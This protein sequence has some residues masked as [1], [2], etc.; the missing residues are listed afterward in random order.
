[1]HVLYR[2]IRVSW[3]QF[4]LYRFILGIVLGIA[5]ALSGLAIADGESNLPA[6]ASTQSLAAIATPPAT[7]L[8][9]QGRQA[10][11]AQRFSEAVAAWE[12]AAALL[13]N[14]PLQQ[15]LAFSYLTAAY[16]Q[17]SQWEVG[18]RTITQSLDILSTAP[19]SAQKLA[20]SAQVHNTLGSLQFARGQTQ[21]ALE[22]WQTAADLYMQAGDE[23]RIFNSLL[24]QI[25]AQQALGYYQ[26]VQ[27]TL[28]TLE[29]R[30]PE[31][32][33]PL[34]VRGY[35]RLGQTYRVLG[36]LTTAQDHLQTALSLA[37][38]RNIATAVILLELANTVQGQGDWEGAIALYHQAERDSDTEI[39]LKARLNRLKLLVQHN[40][41]AARQVASTLPTEIAALPPGRGQIYAYI[42]ASQSLLQLKTPAEVETAAR[43]LAQAVQ[44]SLELQDTR[45]EAYARG[46]LGHAYE[47]SQQWAEAQTLTEQALL[48]AE[49]LNAADIA[50]QWHW[51]Q[52]RLFKQQ[53]QREPALQAYRAAFSTL[54]SLK[55]D[56]VAVSDDLQFSFRDSVEP[57]YR[58][59]VD[60]LL[61][62]DAAMP[63]GL[64]EVASSSAQSRLT[65]ARS[66]IEALQIAELN[67]FFRTACLEAQQVDLEQVS[68]AT[69]AIIY[70]I[71]LPDRLE[72]IASLPGQ[73]LRQYTSPVAQADLEQTLLKWRQFLEKPFT[74]PEGQALGQ[75]LYSW[76]I[77]PMQ[78]ALAETASQTL[79]FVLDGA[80]RNTPMA[81]LYDGDRYLVE[82]YAIA[83]SPGLQ[84]LA[85]RSLQETQVSVLLGG[86]TEPRHG[87]SALFN[88]KDELQT[89][90]AL[91]NSRVLLDQGFTTAALAQQVERT[92]LPIVHLATHGQFS[93]NL[94]DTFIL[95][96]D[97][98]M[99]VNELSR[100]L[101]TGDQNR[102]EP[103]EL[104]V[105]SAC[106]TATGDSRAALG[107]AGISLQSGARST[108]ASLWNLDDASGAYFVSQFYQALAQPHTTKAAALR[109]AQRSLLNN[110]NY[111]HPT[112]WSAYVLVGNW[113]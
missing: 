37:Q 93:S 87:F 78:T 70:P 89:I 17:L 41:D 67:N 105:L 21:S 57:V 16:Q 111:R 72:I 10:Y 27:N 81:A 53:G 104:L 31:Q 44:Q 29:Q 8:L 23:S 112:Y 5:I 108:L 34:Q 77:E 99:P 86:L 110:P 68:Q 61:Q 9:D 73:P 46:Y 63:R 13:S 85:P 38:Q 11:A 92:E 91:F 103:I 82:D 52:G 62:P 18:D 76:I 101:R 97:R 96:W 30:L 26:Q 40:P 74:A 35:Q 109:Q 54:Q 14:Q 39:R 7:S 84:L 28:T 95:A 79:V 6:A 98:P 83:L 71:I 20:V 1:M 94:K 33:L 55:Q 69:T 113:L 80:L 25:Q 88:V 22:T 106:E 42:N 56:L 102:L 100:L 43:L 59:L 66:V 60:L 65:E 32:S 75:Q 36:D 15:A 64:A 4:R 12:E 19:D 51:Q 24:N 49:S 107:L 58:E 2:I 90:Q 47:I 45:A 3:S 48:L 50:Y